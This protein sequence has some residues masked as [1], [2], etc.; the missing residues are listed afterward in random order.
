MCGIAGFWSF[1]GAVNP[2]EGSRIGIA[3]AHAMRKRGPDHQNIRVE[4]E[5]GLVMAHAR[6]SIIDLSDAAN[7]PFVS[8]DGRSTI[9]FNGEIYN[10]KLLRDKLRQA[11]FSFRTD[12]D[13]EV[14]LYACRYWGVKGAAKRLIGMFAFAYWDA[15]MRC[16]YLVRDPMGIKPLFYGQSGDSFLFASTL[17]SLRQHPNFHGQ[18]SQESLA[19]F[20]R[21]SYI[22]APHTIFTGFHKLLP[23][24]LLAIKEGGKESLECYWDSLRVAQQGLSSP[25]VGSEVNILDAFDSVLKDS[26]RGCMISDVPLGAFLSGGIDSSLVAAL[27]QSEGKGRAKTFTVGF[28]DARFDESGYARQVASHLGCEHTEIICTTREAL[29]LIADIPECY[30]EPFADS[31]QIPTMLLSKLTQQ[32]VKVVLSGDGGDE[33]FGGYDRYSWMMRLQ[34]IQTQWPD[35]SLRLISALAG[36]YTRDTTFP[37]LS[38]FPK[39]SHAIQ[40]L[41]GWY[42]LARMLEHK[43]DYSYL[44]RTT[45]MT[46]CA[47]RDSKLLLHERELPS[48]LDD[49][50]LKDSLPSGIVPWMQYIDQQTYLPEDILQKVDRASMAYSLEARVPLLDHR[51]V[52]LAWRVPAQ[53]KLVDGRGKIIMR[54]LLARYL[55]NN[56]IERPKQGFS[57]PLSDWL[58]QDLRPWAENLIDSAKLDPLFIKEDVFSLWNNFLTGRAEHTLST[59]WNLLM[60]VQWSL[61][62][63]KSGS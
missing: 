47:Y 43:D 1:S 22:P 10:F 27:M 35:S 37:F 39:G 29:D 46:V 61:A 50:A 41:D 30:D 24:H 23:G 2:E 20:L 53:L 40:W 12:S 33:L 21:Y 34:R 60:Y 42:H 19:T 14:L 44:Y 9:V 59:V 57:V 38:K 45:P 6:L 15:D 49:Q 52:E 48:K 28:S 17:T 5:V 8:D 25:M 11:G 26:I 63:K 51:V 62:H 18:I 56:L 55:P 31:S 7:Q 4:S 13:T 54:K 3:M 16:L 58:K 36:H 32:S